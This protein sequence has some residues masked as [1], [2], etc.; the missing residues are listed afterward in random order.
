MFADVIGMVASLTGMISLMPQ[1]IKVWQTKS[2]GDL[3]LHWFSISCLSN[4]C[5]LTYGFMVSSFPLIVSNII[6]L[7]MM[8]TLLRFKVR[9]G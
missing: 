2:T 5:W 9:Y 3:S 6:V 8:S 1:V 7:G 4:A